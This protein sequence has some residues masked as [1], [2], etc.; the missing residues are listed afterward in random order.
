[1]VP[2]FEEVVFTMEVGD[3]SDVIESEFGYH[4]IKIIDIRD[5]RVKLE[6]SDVSEAIA[7]ILTL[8]K[9]E[10]A[11]DSLVTALKSRARIEYMDEALGIERPD[12][13]LGSP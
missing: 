10:A 8:K 6:F 5:A 12:T 3:V 7:N 11:Y 4:I 2:E 1:M 9:R 13:L